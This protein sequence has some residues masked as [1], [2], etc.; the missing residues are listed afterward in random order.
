VGENTNLGASTVTAN[1]DGFNKNRTK[2]G[3]NVRTGVDTTLI[4]PV[5]IGDDAYTG[6]GSVISEDVSSGALGLSRPD[7]VEIEGYAERKAAKHAKENT[8]GS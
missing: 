7:Q 8:E 4:A 2:I 5:E 1:Y 6:A 3:R